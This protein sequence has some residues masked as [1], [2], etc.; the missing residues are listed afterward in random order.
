MQETG[1]HQSYY[2]PGMSKTIPS[3]T[4][5]YSRL[6]RGWV[7]ELHRIHA[8]LVTPPHSIEQHIG[9]SRPASAVSS[10]AS[11][12]VWNLAPAEVTKVRDIST[13]LMRAEH[14]ETM[15][16]HAAWSEP[17]NLP[18]GLTTMLPFSLVDS[19]A[20]CTHDQFKRC[21]LLLVIATSNFHKCQTQFSFCLSF[22]I[23]FISPQMIG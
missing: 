13:S 16:P 21:A 2:V 4:T 12:G 5:C 9:D 19:K 8:Y 7:S 23:S 15:E 22:P 11:T 18:A 6:Y 14:G 1:N 10:S 20:V 3:V 17:I